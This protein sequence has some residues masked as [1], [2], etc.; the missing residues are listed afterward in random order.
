MKMRIVMI[1]SLLMYFVNVNVFGSN[2]QNSLNKDMKEMEI[3]DIRLDVN[4]MKEN[5]HDL[6]KRVIDNENT[7]ELLENDKQYLKH[8]VENLK[9][10][11]SCETEVLH[12]ITGEHQKELNETNFELNHTYSF[13]KR[14]QELSCTVDVIDN[15]ILCLEMSKSRDSFMKCMTETGV[16]SI[17]TFE[18][19]V[20][21]NCLFYDD[22][23]GLDKKNWRRHSGKTSSL[24]TGP[25]RAKT[26]NDYIYIKS[27]SMDYLENALLVSNIPK[28]DV[29]LSLSFNYHMYGSSTGTLEVIVISSGTNQTIFTRSGDQGNQWYYQKLYI[30]SASNLQIMF[31]AIDGNSSYGEIALDNIML[32]A[33][34][35]GPQTI[36]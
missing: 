34:E 3:A 25:S 17:C 9:R 21:E 23:T 29:K 18:T 33:D 2:T 8:E 1:F 10:Q 15:K 24:N 11:L 5:Y 6:L 22:E 35:C 28:Q 30:Q 4:V 31:N 27:R 36:P 20:D 26:G 14:V 16:V 32:I 12:D 19:K 13:N 7:I